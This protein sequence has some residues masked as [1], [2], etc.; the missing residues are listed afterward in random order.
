[1]K[2]RISYTVD[3]EEIPSKVDDLLD[4]AHLL[5]LKIKDQPVNQVKDTNL[6][7]VLEQIEQKR[8]MLLDVDTKMSDAYNVLVGYMQALVEKKAQN[9]Q[10]NP[11]EEGDAEDDTQSE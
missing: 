7:E 10:K 6:M 9:I 3:F 2:V 5:I 11:S 1:M 8:K 4:D